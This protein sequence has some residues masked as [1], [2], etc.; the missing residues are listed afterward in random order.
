MIHRFDVT[1]SNVNI[2]LFICSAAV[3]TM[4]LRTSAVRSVKVLLRL[5]ILLAAVVSSSAL[6]P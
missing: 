5:P 4:R 1:V 2:V 3:A 6:V